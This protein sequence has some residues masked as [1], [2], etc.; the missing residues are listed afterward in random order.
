MS[1]GLVA[2]ILALFVVMASTHS[3]WGRPVCFPTS[4]ADTRKYR[5]TD[6]QFSVEI[7]LRLHACKSSSPCPNHG[8]WFPLKDDLDCHDYPQVPYIDVDAEYNA[9]EESDSAEGLA[10]IQCRDRG[11]R[12]IVWLKEE[13]LSGR[14]A[15]GCWRD[16]RDGH[17]EVSLIVLR[18]TNESPGAW[19]EVAVDLVTTPARYETDMHG[20][21]EVL[22]GIWVHPDGPHP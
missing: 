2:G 12:N 19:I 10:A 3:G 17:I 9:A 13:H 18:R 6:Y 14:D 8:I 21:R 20:Y 16:F 11:A 22:R 15:A 1:A 4:I 5:N 7:P